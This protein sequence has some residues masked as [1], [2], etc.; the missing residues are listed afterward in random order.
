VIRTLLNPKTSQKEISRELQEYLE[1]RN[2]TFAE[3]V[4][5]VVGCAA[6][7]VAMHQCSSSENQDEYENRIVDFVTLTDLKTNCYDSVMLKHL[8]PSI[9][10][11]INMNIQKN[12]R[13]YYRLKMVEILID[14]FE[15][16]DNRIYL[17]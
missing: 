15:R 10:K 5:T 3:N 7:L 14:N 2:F 8:I 11:R 17:C 6:V 9:N 4:R 12:I 1:F 16:V 13:Q